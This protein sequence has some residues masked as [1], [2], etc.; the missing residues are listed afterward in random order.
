[1]T[2]APPAT[3]VPFA[4]AMRIIHG[5]LVASMALAGGVFA[6]LVQGQGRSFGVPRNVGIVLAGVA[7]SLLVVA[8]TML[9]RKVPERRFDQ[10]Q[11]DY[12]ASPD[13]RGTSVLLW[14]VADGAGLAGLVGY[15][16]T[17]G[18]VPAAAAVLSILALIA[19][20]PAS[21]EREGG[22]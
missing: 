20:R 21:L 3:P 6:L 2:Q 8:S 22:A 4:R 1:V 15:L 10:S 5:C 18:A 14:A 16:L 11:D 19:F 17:G 12:W 7:V 9:R 13:T